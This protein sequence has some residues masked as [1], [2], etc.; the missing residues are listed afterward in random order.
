MSDG[1]HDPRRDDEFDAIQPSLDTI[2]LEKFDARDRH[3]LSKFSVLDQRVQL[4]N[5]R[6]GSANGSIEAL[7]QRV[8]SLDK[9]V[10]IL[11]KLSEKLTSFWGFL[12]ILAAAIAAIMKIV[13]VIIRMM[14]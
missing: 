7:E 11:E 1:N 3:V 4:L 14:R 9:K 5:R 10:Q 6:I 2:V 8:A 12:L 13:E